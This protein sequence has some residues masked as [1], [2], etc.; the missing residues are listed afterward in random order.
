MTKKRRKAIM[1][2]LEKMEITTEADR[3]REKVYPSDYERQWRKKYG[4][5]F[6]E[7]TLFDLIFGR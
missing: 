6:E 1:K 3:N 2:H 5:K 4:D 7:M